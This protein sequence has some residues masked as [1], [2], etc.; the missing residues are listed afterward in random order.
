MRDRNEFLSFLKAHPNVSRET[1]E[2][3]DIYRATLVKWQK[4]I[5]LV[6]QSTLADVWRRHFLDSAQ[7][8]N[9]FRGTEKT[10]V[11]IGSGA[12]FPGLVLALMGVPDV[13]LVESDKKK[14]PFSWRSLGRPAH[15]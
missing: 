7:L 13:H 6:S 8:L 3:L 11:D 12:G 14:A 10:I 5:N 1:M 4:R 15:G 9:A 2:R